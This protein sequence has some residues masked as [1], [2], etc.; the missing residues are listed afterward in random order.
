MSFKMQCE[1]KVIEKRKPN[2]YAKKVDDTEVSKNSAAQERAYAEKHRLQVD[3]KVII[4]R[5][6]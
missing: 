5:C 4:H 6:L 2:H 1:K 3:G